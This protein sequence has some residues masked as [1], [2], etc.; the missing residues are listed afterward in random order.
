MKKKIYVMV[1]FMLIA[2]GMVG[3]ERLPTIGGDTGNWGNVLNGFLGV[4]LDQNGTIKNNT[5]TAVMMDLEDITL[6]VFT[7]DLTTFDINGV[8]GDYTEK[9]LNVNGIIRAINDNTASFR[10][11]G[12]CDGSTDDRVYNS[13]C[14]SYAGIFYN[15]VY[16]NTGGLGARTTRVIYGSNEDM[17]LEIQGSNHIRITA[18]DGDVGNGRIRLAAEDEIQLH[19][20]ATA[21]KDGRYLIID[22]VDGT[23]DTDLRLSVNTGNL[24]LNNGW[25]GTCPA[26]NDTVVVGGVITGCV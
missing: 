4:S 25:T 8:V 1:A 10:F 17:D 18:V 24:L 3:A 16:A 13:T 21:E 2:M 20:G 22:T 15:N 5:I 26:G 6:S 11:S 12:V 23:K 7:N 19:V 9:T 14:Q